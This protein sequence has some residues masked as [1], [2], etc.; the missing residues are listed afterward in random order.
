MRESTS[1]RTRE[2]KLNLLSVSSQLHSK[3]EIN[4][5]KMSRLSFWGTGVFSLLLQFCMSPLYPFKHQSCNKE[6][7]CVR[8]LHFKHH[9]CF[10]IH[11]RSNLFSS[12]R[13][14]KCCGNAIRTEQY[15]L[16][17]PSF[18]PEISSSGS[19]NYLI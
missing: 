4:H 1:E 19:W 12:S 9:R 2:I 8:K 3:A 15:G 7:L 11:H 10:L 18:V 6:H 13:F 5:C 16:L 17:V 14:F